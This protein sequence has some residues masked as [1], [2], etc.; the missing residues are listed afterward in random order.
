MVAS[1]KERNENSVN[2]ALSE[3]MG[4]EDDRQR[5]EEEDAKKRKMQKEQQ[6]RE[7]EQQRLEEEETARRLLEN[8]RLRAERERYDEEE[9]KIREEEER[10][11]RIRLE[12]EARA[13]AEVEE[14]MLMQEMEVRRIEA[15]AKKRVTGWMLGVAAL[16][17]CIN[18]GVAAGLHT[19]SLAEAEQQLRTERTDWERWRREFDAQLA[20]ARSEV[21]AIAEKADAAKNAAANLRDQLEKRGT[22]L[23]L[24]GKPHRTQRPHRPK[25]ITKRP[26]NTTPSPGD[27]EGS[28][29]FLELDE[30]PI[31]EKDP[32]GEN[33][34]KKR[35]KR[36]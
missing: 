15:G 31:S 36:R 20:G 8:E 6:R 9:Q 7:M 27:L 26:P 19:K 4:L 18:A 2:V 1:K 23:A 22:E 28:S 32:F 3:L 10:K 5:A 35:K 34:K 33:E 29:G 12:A 13:R 24:N 11:V 30:D 16:V 25:R 17:I 14:R 21:N